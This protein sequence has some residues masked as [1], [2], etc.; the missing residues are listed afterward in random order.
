LY[1]VSHNPLQKDVEQLTAYNLDLTN[2][3]TRLDQA[4]QDLT[5]KYQDLQ[6]AQAQLQGDLGKLQD[7]H[8]QLQQ[9]HDQ[10]QADYQALQK[11]YTDLRAYS[12]Q[13]NSNFAAFRD[14]AI[15]PPY[16]YIH[17][18]QVTMAFVKI[19]GSIERW[20]VPFD[21]LETDLEHGHQVR[22]LDNQLLPRLDLFNSTTQE[23][24]HA[25]DFRPLI[26]GETF[27][28]VIPV[29]YYASGGD[30]R[31]LQEAWNIV[32]QL[33]VYSV[34]IGEA[35]RYPLETLLASGGDC[36][37]TAI[38]L[39][40]MLKAAPVDWK[41]YLLYMDGD[42]PTAPVAMNHVAV[43]VDT[44]QRQYTIETTE[45][46]TMQPYSNGVS[47]WYIETL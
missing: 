19:D 1:F 21:R 20:E 2:T 40:S 33:S 26:D 17:G 45:H 10:L 28:R 37:D 27:S 42:H 43:Y 39:A 35:P 23:H 14:I 31:F 5:L 46:Q 25:V 11:N 38:L 12:D 4:H 36:E 34:D 22:A 32:T 15:A 16:I 18:R 44:G 6:T 47:G 30:E 24:Y 29:L 8:I 7:Q 9:Q 41:I 3:Y 13:L